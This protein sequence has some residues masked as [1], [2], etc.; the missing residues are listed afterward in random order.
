MGT[1]GQVCLKLRSYYKTNTLA[2][3]VCCLSVEGD[4]VP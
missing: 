4:H 1:S 2:L 3:S